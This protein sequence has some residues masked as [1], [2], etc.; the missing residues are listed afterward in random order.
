MHS[1]AVIFERLGPYHVARLEALGRL[2]RVDA[3]EV[4][5]RDRTYAWDPIERIG[6]PRVT[7]FE[8][9]AKRVGRKLRLAMAQALERIGADAVAIPGWSADYTIAA[10]SWCAENGV[11]AVLMSD[12]TAQDAPRVAWREAVKR[13]LVSLCGGALVGGR[14]HVEYLVSLGMAGERIHVGYDV[15]DN[16]HF[17]RGTQEA[18]KDAEAVRRR[19]GL[20]EHY[21][22]A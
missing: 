2:A 9:G 1:V 17:A 18:R 10:L 7:L 8:S 3:V 22:L 11:P 20:P 13:R 14:R 6:I 21:F 16:G 15:V 5:A 4:M 19:F 12:T